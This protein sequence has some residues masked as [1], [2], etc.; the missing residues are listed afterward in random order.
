M[1]SNLA[2]FVAAVVTAVVKAA[3]IRLHGSV[4]AGSGRAVSSVVDASSTASAD[5]VATLLAGTGIDDSTVVLEV[6][7]GL[8]DGA[9]VAIIVGKDA[10]LLGEVVAVH[11]T[12]R[13]DVLQ[14][15][16]GQPSAIGLDIVIVFDAGFA[17]GVLVAPD[18][19]NGTIVG[20]LRSITTA[21]TGILVAGVVTHTVGVSGTRVS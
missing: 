1:S 9:H 2:P 8:I 11:D 4:D 6:A 12:A 5:V 15:T 13:I 3:S 7:H 17:I 14:R 16:L 20:S 18:L 21:D 19:G 10:R